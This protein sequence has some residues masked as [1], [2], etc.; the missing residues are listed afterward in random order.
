MAN[1]SSATNSWAAAYALRGATRSLAAIESSKR[2]VVRCVSDLADRD[3]LKL[4]AA[5]AAAAGVISTAVFSNTMSNITAGVKV[6]C[7]KP[8]MSACI[9]AKVA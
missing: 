9:H 8:V 1:F 3:L 4:R 7:P 2:S 5:T 6:S